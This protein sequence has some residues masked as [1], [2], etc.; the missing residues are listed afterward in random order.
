MNSIVKNLFG[1]YL[2]VLLFRRHF[3]ILGW[4]VTA[5]GTRLSSV[6]S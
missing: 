6:R 2:A 4:S 5:S 3:A 1:D